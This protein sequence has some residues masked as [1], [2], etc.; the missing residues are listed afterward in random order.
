SAID[1]TRLDC[2]I[3]HAGTPHIDAVN[4]LSIH[5]RRRV[6]ALEALADDLPVFRVLELDLGRRFDLARG[7]GDLAVAGAAVRRLMRNHALVDTALRGGDLPL[8]GGRLEEHHA[9][10]GA[11][12]A[13]KIIRLT[14]AAASRSEEV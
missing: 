9:R 13:H 6:E 3:E 4:R 8:L 2:C 12:L 14:N 7:F 11:A 5:L 1:G 10:G